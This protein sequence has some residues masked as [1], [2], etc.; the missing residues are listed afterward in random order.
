ME[1]SYE[2]LRLLESGHNKK[3]G[4]PRE[5]AQLLRHREATRFSE[6]D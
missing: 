6:N 1:I 2:Q 3:A 5:A 4:R